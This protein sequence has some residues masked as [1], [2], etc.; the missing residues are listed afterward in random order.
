MKYV[1]VALVALSVMACTVTRADVEA[2]EK[3]AA[4]AQRYAE[5]AQD[6]AVRAERLAERMGSDEAKRIAEEA[7]AAAAAAA[8]AAADVKANPPKEGEPWW[9]VIGAIVGGAVSAFGGYRAGLYHPVPK[10]KD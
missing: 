7:R 9:M 2:W 5:Q 4:S 1:I 6:I 8:A 10:L 3:H